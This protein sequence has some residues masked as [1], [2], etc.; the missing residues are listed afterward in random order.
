M[1]DKIGSGSF[2]ET[3]MASHQGREVAVKIFPVNN[4]KYSVNLELR[5]YVSISSIILFIYLF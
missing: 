5:M 3:F 1:G 4:L 2:G